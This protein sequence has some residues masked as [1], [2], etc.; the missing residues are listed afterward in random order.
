MV[1][2]LFEGITC[3]NSRTVEPLIG[4]ILNEVHFCVLWKICNS[5][6]TEPKWT[7]LPL[8][9]CSTNINSEP[10]VKITIVKCRLLILNHYHAAAKINVKDILAIGLEDSL[11]EGLVPKCGD[12]TPTKRHQ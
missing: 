4:E 2:T 10:W 6:V 11:Y 8:C 3:K 9:P 5:L 1:C 7:K 12:F